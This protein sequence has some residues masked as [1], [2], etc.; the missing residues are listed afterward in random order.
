[1][2]INPSNYVRKNQITQSYSLI[3]QQNFLDSLSLSSNSSPKMMEHSNEI[4]SSNTPVM[5]KTYEIHPNG[6]FGFRQISDR[7]IDPLK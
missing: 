1:M 6:Q 2:K 4:D 7:Y 3:S 5:T